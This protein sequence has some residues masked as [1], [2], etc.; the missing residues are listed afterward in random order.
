MNG[1]KKIFLDTNIL[2]YF[3]DKESPFF[4]EANRFLSYCFSNEIQIGISSLLL[5]EYLVDVYRKKLT[6]VDFFLFLENANFEICD[7]DQISAKKAA[8]LKAKYNEKL[9]DLIHIATALENKYDYF[10]TNDA[11]LK[12]IIDISVLNLREFFDKF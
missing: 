7:F 8:R 11:N 5:T 2:I 9:P 6:D 10:L 4:E 12:N 3:F 1:N